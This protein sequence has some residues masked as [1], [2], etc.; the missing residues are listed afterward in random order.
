MSDPS[1][2]AATN[3]NTRYH[4]S[5]SEGNSNE[6]SESS[7]SDRFAH[8]VPVDDLNDHTED[9]INRVPGHKLI[10]SDGNMDDHGLKEL[11]PSSDGINPSTKSCDKQ[12]A[13]ENHSQQSLYPPSTSTTEKSKKRQPENADVEGY[14][15]LSCISLSKEEVDAPKTVSQPLHDVFSLTNGRGEVRN[16]IHIGSLFPPYTFCRF[17][18][19]YSG[20]LSNLINAKSMRDVKHAYDPTANISKHNIS[21]EV[22]EK[23][24]QKELLNHSL[25]LLSKD[26]LL[27]GVSSSL[28]RYLKDDLLYMWHRN[29]FSFPVSIHFNCVKQALHRKSNSKGEFMILHTPSPI[30]NMM[31]W[32]EIFSDTNVQMYD[33]AYDTFAEVEKT[34]YL[35]TTVTAFPIKE[36]RETLKQSLKGTSQPTAS[37]GITDKTAMN[38][39][40]LLMKYNIV[41]LFREAVNYNCHVSVSY[42]MKALASAPKQYFSSGMS[43]DEA[44]L[45][46]AVKHYGIDKDKL[47]NIFTNYFHSRVT[48]SLRNLFDD[49]SSSH[50]IWMNPLPWRHYLFLFKLWNNDYRIQM[51]VKRCFTKHL[52]HYDQ[53]SRNQF[54]EI[55]EL[56]TTNGVVKW[57]KVIERCED[58]GEQAFLACGNTKHQVDEAVEV[59]MT[60]TAM[61]SP[62][63]FWSLNWFKDTNSSGKNATHHNNKRATSKTEDKPTVAMTETSENVVAM[64]TNQKPK[65]NSTVKTQTNTSSSGPNSSQTQ[66]NGKPGVSKVDSEEHHHYLPKSSSNKDYQR[67]NN[68]NTTSKYQHRKAQQSKPPQPP[69]QTSQPPSQTSPPP[70]P[71]AQQPP[72]SMQ[73]HPHGTHYAPYPYNVPTYPRQYMYPPHNVPQHLAPSNHAP[74]KDGYQHTYHPPNY[75]HGSQLQIMRPNNVHPSQSQPKNNYAGIYGGARPISSHPPP[76]H[77][78]HGRND[79]PFRSQGNQ[80]N[81]SGGHAFVAVQDSQ[82]IDDEDPH[83]QPEWEQWSE[84]E[85]YT[86]DTTTSQESAYTNVEAELDSINKQ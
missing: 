48:K 16:M 32:D 5:G 76:Q 74:P 12:T 45:T 80:R 36:A 41:G 27:S 62:Y 56:H 3:N 28:R 61:V 2:S 54:E 17:I 58:C 40:E 65:V 55:V 35:H 37:I 23:N 31:E 11:L 26:E 84:F 29:E 46:Y 15:D 4:F 1:C 21:P 51:E 20:V 69:L 71:F 67:S 86:D 78:N 8:N 79:Q 72:Y 82:S 34:G 70:P 85:Q 66:Y 53:D 42:I 68:Y 64:A 14:N 49:I 63:V 33:V 77:G 75:H 22:L 47:V 38:K 6:S 50:C 57:S 25:R 44:V 60:R 43:D 9:M 59:A 83:Y 39:I 81:Q 24:V 13:N 73:Q 30:I 19:R 7:S 18:R 10:K 52:Q